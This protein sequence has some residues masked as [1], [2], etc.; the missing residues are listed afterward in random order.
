MSD[1]DRKSANLTRR[2]AL[3]A[4]AAVTGALVIGFWM[5]RRAQAPLATPEGAVWAD[6]EPETSEVNA[7]VVVDFDDT[8]TVRIAQ[9]E[10]GQGVWT[11]NAMMVAEELQCDWSKVRPQ[12]ASANRDAREMAPEWTLKVPG[13]G[14]T[15]PSGG[16]EPQFGTRDRTGLAGIPDSLYRRMRTNAAASV[17]DG[18]YYLQLA[19]AEARERL[20]LAAAKTWGVPVEEVSSANS[21]IAH[22]STGRTT[23][24]GKVASLAAQTPHPNPE[25]IRIK[26]PSEW[27]LMGTEQKN[28]DVP[29]KVTGKAVYGIDVHMPGMKWAAVKSCPVYGGKVKSYDFE[30]I[31]S[32]PGVISAIQFPIPEPK[33]IRGRI[34]GGGVAVIADSWYQAKTAIEKMPIEWDIPPEYA[35]LTTA[36]LRAKLMASLDE[37]GRVGV[38]VG[39]CDTAFRSGARIVEATYSV[40]YL[41]RARMEPG[42]ATVLVTDDRVDIWLGD[43]SPQETRRS[44]AEIT[45]IPEANVYLHMCHLGGGYGRNGNGPQAEQAIYIANLNRGTPIHLLWT[46]EEDFINTTYRSI[47]VAKLRAALDRDGWPIA[48]EVRTATDSEAPGQ[49]AGFDIAARY[50]APNYR[51][52]MH[53]AKFH[54]PVGTRRGVGAPAQHF[55]RESFMDELAHAAGKDPYQYRRELISRTDLPYK[56]DMIKAL[57]MAAEMSGW[58]TPLPEGTARAI[59]LEERGGE[60][61]HHATISAQVHTVSVSKD[62]KVR[63]ERVDVAHDEGFGLVN[64]L[65]VKKQIEGQITW[66]YNDAI[67]QECNV[68]DGRIVENNF[69]AFPL[70]RMSENPPEINIRFFKSGHW[71]DGMGHDR[72]PAI[73]SAIADC[74]FQITKKRY[75]DLPLRN[76]DLTWT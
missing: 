67:Y 31:R 25:G 61:G 18:R 54:I 68:K 53:S 23:T 28:L 22:G 32:E 14:A 8:V 50:H 72:G 30:K 58:G 10:L 33:L 57:D 51:F 65:S 38:N 42:N 45:G 3:L 55:Y 34:F 52:S 16:G 35:S 17:K 63:V 74:V 15:D 60:E 19:G 48:I 69:D 27:T 37:T 1:N 56:A 76:H 26:P 59:A 36:D 75:R 43:Q 73:Q 62:G 66:F 70:S 44:C 64:P 21:V 41:P 6:E 7:W 47:G 11:S 39:D 40:P 5:P 20:L 46:R 29:S 2:G 9:T 49:N 71:L 24:Y 12:Y 13:N 4:G